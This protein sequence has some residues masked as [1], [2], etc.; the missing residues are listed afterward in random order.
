MVVVIA[1]QGAVFQYVKFKGKIYVEKGDT[2]GH[3]YAVAQ[4]TERARL[5]KI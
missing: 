1:F 5:D 3:K 4:T 2:Y